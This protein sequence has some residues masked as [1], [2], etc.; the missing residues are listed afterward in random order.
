MLPIHR[1]VLRSYCSCGHHPHPR[2]APELT[3]TVRNN[4]NHDII[5]ELLLRI[6]VMRVVMVVRV[7]PC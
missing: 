4:D 5:T 7:V 2:D 3:D 6:V 1:H